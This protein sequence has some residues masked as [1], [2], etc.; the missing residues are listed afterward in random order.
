MTPAKTSLLAAFL[1]VFTCLPGP[2]V[3][4][5]VSQSTG[6]CL[7][8]HS[9]EG[10]APFVDVT[11]LK[12]SAHG[13]VSCV[14]CHAQASPIPHPEKLT[15]VN[16]GSC[17]SSETTQYLAGQ[18]GIKVGG[19]RSQAETCGDCHGKP[20]GILPTSDQNSPVYRS[21]VP[22]LC[23]SCHDNSER[24]KNTH[25]AQKRPYNSY[26][27]SVHGKAF[28]RGNERVPVCSDCHGLHRLLSASDHGSEIF[29][30]NVPATCGRCHGKELA[31]FDKS[32][33]ARA[34]RA[35][36]DEAPVCTDCHGEHL[37]LSSKNP[38]SLIYPATIEKT[39]SSCHDAERINSA[40]E[41]PN[42]RSRTYD[43]SYHGLAARYGS[44]TVANCASCHGNHDILPSSDPASSVNRANLSATCGKC[45]PGA[46]T[47]LARGYVHSTPITSKNTVVRYVI[48]FYLLLITLVIGGMLL[49]NVVDFLRKLVNHFRVM[50][51][52]AAE[53]RF[54]LSERL[55]HVVLTITFVVL[56][57][58]GFARRFPDA[59]WSSPF[60]LFEDPSSARGLFHRVAAAVFIALCLYHIWF[61]LLTRRGR[62]QLGELKPGWK[63]FGD[64]LSTAKYNAGISKAPSQF[65][66]YNYI[67]KSEYWALV[68]GS[69]IM[70]ITGLGLVFENFTL[71]YFPLWVA[72]LFTSIHFYEAVLATLAI[73]VWHFYWTIFDPHVYPMNWS[74]ITGRTAEKRLG[75][76]E[77]VKLREKSKPEPRQNGGGSKATK[78][79]RGVESQQNTQAAPEAGGPQSPEERE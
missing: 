47:K 20:H 50:K 75:K 61:I 64:L 65:G 23:A 68:W 17:H 3:S 9:E 60:R 76:A 16:C 6:D 77:S 73:L 53:F 11:S 37:I 31:A 56:A 36:I 71:R 5:A 44:I 38:L 42:D 22:S 30:Q 15:P 26:M 43:Q 70:I 59:W 35:G 28:D 52:H 58:S 39:C 27:E 25:L 32:V 13:G 4:D 57:Y 51:S 54:V 55:Q 24:M 18:H 14:S 34:I 2:L 41:L 49:H 62:E 40:Y 12:G 21:R 72:E 48:T 46:G 69:V 63:D 45:H 78:S 10:G 67:E 8:C 29:R 79:P 19:E 33:H 74:W 1:L 7:M 66:R